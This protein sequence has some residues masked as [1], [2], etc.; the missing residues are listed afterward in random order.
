[1]R[2]ILSQPA[3]GFAI[4]VVRRD[5]RQRVVAVPVTAAVDAAIR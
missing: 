4:L 3:A 1:V 2:A 5:W